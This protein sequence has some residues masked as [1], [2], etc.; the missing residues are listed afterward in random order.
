MVDDPNDD[1]S[2]SSNAS[3]GSRHSDPSVTADADLALADLRAEMSAERIR[4]DRVAVERSRS[5]VQPAELLAHC[6]GST[7]TVLLRGSTSSTGTVTEVGRDYVCIDTSVGPL[8]IALGAVLAVTGQVDPGLAA[9]A[10]HTIDSSLVD[11]LEDLMFAESE[12]AVSLVNGDR[13]SGRIVGVGASVTLGDDNGFTLI[14]LSAIAKLNCP[15]TRF[16]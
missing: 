5:E 2:G 15:K 14:A 6:S 12:V 4:R 16:R 11:V 10:G 9:G 13:L 1:V 3:D 8:W 7:V